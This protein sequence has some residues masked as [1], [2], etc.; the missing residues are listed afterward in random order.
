MTAIYINSSVRKG[1]MELTSRFIT[2]SPV[3]VA[4]K[5]LAPTWGMTQSQWLFLWNELA[6]GNK[7][8]KAVTSAIMSWTSLDSQD[9]CDRV[10]FQKGFEDVFPDD[11]ISGLRAQNKATRGTRR[12]TFN[13]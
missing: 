8:H 6:S 11:T 10:K 1:R 12:G 2:N 5:G 13:V 9:T 4:K 3:R 7:S